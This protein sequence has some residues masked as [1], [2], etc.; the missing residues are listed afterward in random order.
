VA[1]N[2]VLVVDFVALFAISCCSLIRNG[3]EDADGY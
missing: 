2:A 3:S 1:G